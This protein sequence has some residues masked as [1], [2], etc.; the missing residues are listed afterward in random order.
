MEVFKQSSDRQIDLT[1]AMFLVLDVA[2]QSI[3]SIMKHKLNV[4]SRLVT[5]T[6]VSKNYAQ[7]IYPASRE[8]MKFAL[9]SDGKKTNTSHV[10][11]GN[12]PDFNC[13]T[14]FTCVLDFHRRSNGHSLLTKAVQYRLYG[15]ISVLASYSPDSMGDALAYAV[16]LHRSLSIVVFSNTLKRFTMVMIWLRRC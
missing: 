8:L 6:T 7:W 4:G 5:R 1:P 10:F 3:Y 16:R 13:R 15:I 12:V 2:Q 14:M 11:L 9:P